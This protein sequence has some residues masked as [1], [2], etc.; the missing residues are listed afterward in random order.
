MSSAPHIWETTITRNIGIDYGFLK[1]RVSGSLDFYWNSTNDLLMRARVQ[2]SSGYLYQYQ[3]FGSTE[4]K[5]VE[6]ST[7]VVIFENNRFSLNGNLNI[8]YNRNKITKLNNDDPFQSSSFAGSTIAEY[9]D[10]YV[11]EGGRLGEIWGFQYNGYYT[12]DELILGADG[13]WSSKDGNNYTYS[14][15]TLYPGAPKYIDQNGDGKIDA[16]NDKVRLGNTVPTWTGGFGLDGSVKARW[17]TIDASIFFNYS[18]GN[19]ILN[20]T[21]LANSFYAGSS[22]GY[23]LVSEFNVDNRYAWVDPATGLNI[24]RPSPNTIIAYGGATAVANRLDEMNAGKELWCPT[25][26]TAM[27]ISDWALEDASFLR[28]QSITIGY[29]LPKAW[30]K[31]I[32]LQKVRIYFTG[33]NLA[34]WTKY[35]GYDPE[36]SAS[37]NPMCPGID[38]AMYPKSRSYTVGLNVQF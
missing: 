28:L 2:S 24:G 14:E 3:N 25:A 34:C 37:S 21:K 17:G 18:L 32:Y 27:V 16:K 29:S 26:T 15:A 8:A 13:K 31:K 30:L 12:A 9:N 35:S 4:N 5:G 11:T 33:H 10:F 20:G 23:N 38:F 22:A 7:N 19:K 36:V 1:G 6:F